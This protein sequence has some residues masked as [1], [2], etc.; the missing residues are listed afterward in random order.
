LIILHQS[1]TKALE[2]LWPAPHRCSPVVS[3]L[4]FLSGLP[5]KRVS[6]DE[7]VDFYTSSVGAVCGKQFVY[8]HFVSL[9]EKLRTV[10]SNNLSLMKAG[11][12]S[13]QHLSASERQMQALTAN[14]QELARQSAA[15]CREIQEL[16]KHNQELISLLRS[17]GEIPNPGQGREGGDG[18]RNEEGRNQ[19]QDQMT[20]GAP[21]IR[22]ENPL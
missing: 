4:F 11:D 3:L 19:N 7:R 2:E 20:K 13:G 12:T 8:S 1:L 18:P 17:R 21:P 10:N 22:T 16:T 9:P 6:L 14:V 5:S 15:N